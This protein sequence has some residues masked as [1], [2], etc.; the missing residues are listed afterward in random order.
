MIDIAKEREFIQEVDQKTRRLELEK[1]KLEQAKV[2]TEQQMEQVINKMS[3]LGCTPENID[4]KIQEHSDKITA[5]KSK[6]QSILGD[7]EDTPAD[8]NEFSF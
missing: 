7:K 6:M 3:A 4:E 5:L 2:S 1:A 8:N